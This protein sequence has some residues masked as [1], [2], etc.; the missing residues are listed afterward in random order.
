M[1]RAFC[2]NLSRDGGLMSHDDNFSQEAVPLSA[3]KGILALSFI[4][5]G[6]TF[7]SASMLAGG[8]LGVG[9]SFNQFFLAVLLGNF[10]LGVYTAFL[11]YI[12][13]Q[14]GFT[15]HLLARFSF[16][17]KGSWFPSLL[18]STTQ[19]GWFGVGIAMF[20]LPVSKITG[21]NIYLLIL[22]SGAMM[23][24]TLFFGLSAITALSVL[25]VPSMALLG[26]YS[27]W[28]AIVQGGGL[29]AV[30]QIVP[31]APLSLTEGITIVVGSFVSAGT[32]TADFVRFGRNAKTAVIVALV[33]F[34]LG[35]SLMFIFG[36]GGA[37]TLGVS[38]ISDIMLAQGLILPAIVILGLNIW[39]TNNSALY[40]SSLG[41]SCVTGLPSKLLAIVL[42]TVG[43]L[44]ALWLYNNFVSWLV[45]LS[46]AIPPVGGILIADYLLNKKRY[47]DLANASSRQVNWKAMLAVLVG[48]L[49]A[50]V[51][52]GII[53]VNAILGSLVCYTVLELTFRKNKNLVLQGSYDE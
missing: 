33:A 30:M 32:L 53:P 26:C 9:L 43:T 1:I 31:S 49:C 28:K 7:F 22:V 12:G 19:V 50:Q 10:L 40:A 47:D 18:L 6:L 15:T 35:N 27:V 2:L 42:G 3:R 24:G 25:A 23:T 38:D 13:S 48:I 36:A 46:S 37:A 52:P 34:F 11:G 45:F 8:K 39:T 51:L 20:A 29:E 41:F 17:S 14:T 5:L 44:S 21:I 4:M 16:G